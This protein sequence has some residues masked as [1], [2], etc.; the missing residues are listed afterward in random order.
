MW[1]LIQHFQI[2]NARDE[3]REVAERVESNLDDKI[4]RL[5]LAC[6]AM[7]ELLR[8]QYGLTEEQLMAKMREIDARD[9]ELDGK[10]SVDIVRCPSCGV[11]TFTDERRCRGCGG[12]V[13]PRHTFK[14]S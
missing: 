4:G 7:W 6:Q 8:E 13:K 1:D 12:A 14:P 5:S 2:S 3:A 9:G 10:I 11:T